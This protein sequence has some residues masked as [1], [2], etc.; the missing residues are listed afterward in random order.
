MALSTLVSAIQL[1]C[2]TEN[3]VFLSWELPAGLASMKDESSATAV[4]AVPIDS[5]RPPIGTRRERKAVNPAF[6]SIEEPK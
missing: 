1:L 2:M 4:K 6:G 5:E 3:S